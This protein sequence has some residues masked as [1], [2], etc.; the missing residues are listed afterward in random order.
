MELYLDTADL[1]A[2]Q[3]VSQYLPIQGVTTNPSILARQGIQ[4]KQIVPAIRDFI[5]VNK[6]IFVQVITEHADAMIEEAESILHIDKNAIIKVPVTQAGL[7]AIRQLSSQ[8]VTV[9]GTAIYTP[10]QAFLAGLAGAKYV[11]PYVNRIDAQGG[12]SR[13]ALTEMM[14]LLSQHV[15]GCQIL[16]ASFKSPRQ[17]LDCLLSGCSSIT[18]PIDVAE[19]FLSLPAVDAAVSQFSN[20]WQQKFG[21]Q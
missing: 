3:R 17:V 4:L 19:Q 15:P 13:Q 18:V 20:E 1:Q 21:Q 12:N 10:M 8:G 2:I 14:S 11:A 7:V 6:Q 9:L 16:A 5:G